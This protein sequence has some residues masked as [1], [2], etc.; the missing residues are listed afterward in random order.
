[1]EKKNDHINP[2]GGQIIYIDFEFEWSPLIYKQIDI[3]TFFVLH[4]PY[5]QCLTWHFFPKQGNIFILLFWILSY[6]SWQ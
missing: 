6:F 4:M 3:K 1:M 2:G 5:K